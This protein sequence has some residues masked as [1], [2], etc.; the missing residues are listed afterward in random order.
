MEPTQ[1]MHS[2]ADSSQQLAALA[3]QNCCLQQLV[4]D[5]LHKNELLRQ[6]LAER[7]SANAA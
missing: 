4:A 3:E 2:H 5:L 6:Q 7:S 1:Q